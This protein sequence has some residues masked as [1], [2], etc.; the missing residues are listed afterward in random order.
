MIVIVFVIVVV[1]V[2]VLNMLASVNKIAI[3]RELIKNHD[4]T[5][6]RDS[7]CSR[8]GKENF[9]CDIA[10]ACIQSCRVSVR[11]MRPLE[12]TR[13]GSFLGLCLHCEW[14]GGW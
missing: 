10:L 1:I 14:V 5:I 7:F 11:S 12:G 3:T 9:G 6:P 8:L 13:E 4:E 2:I